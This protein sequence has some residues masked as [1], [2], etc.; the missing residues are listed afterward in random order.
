MIVDIDQ[1]LLRWS[2]GEAGV[3]RGKE[4]EA[5]ADESGG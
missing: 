1:K 3:K 2:F 5:M 4:L